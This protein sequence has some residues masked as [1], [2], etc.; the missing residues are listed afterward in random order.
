[1]T[2]GV[3]F[4]AFGLGGGLLMSTIQIVGETRE[5]ALLLT[6]S[7]VEL[8]A[9]PPWLGFRPRHRVAF[10]DIETVAVHQPRMAA[11]TKGYV[12][13]ALRIVGG[14]RTVDTGVG[15]SMAAI[16]WP[17]GRVSAAVMEADNASG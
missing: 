17:R 5:R 6:R 11:G 8:G 10:S 1:L 15:L 12:D 4:L 14:G 13:R 7:H 2:A 3:V 9:H 16:E